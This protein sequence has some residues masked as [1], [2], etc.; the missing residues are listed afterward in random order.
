MEQETLLNKAIENYNVA[1]MIRNQMDGDEA[2]LNYIGY[3]LQQSVEL[4]I[5]YQLDTQGVEYPKTHDIDQLIFI[6]KRN[7]AQLIMTD[8]IEDHSEMF[9]QWESKT[10]YVL[11]YRLEEKKVDSAIHA[12][13]QY[14][15]KI[16]NRE[17]E[18][19]EHERSENHHRSHDLDWDER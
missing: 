12:V 2:F 1:I 3:H 10:R 13:S 7:N 18:L 8:Y 6:A 9:S 16:L 5:K 19:S 4:C 17:I 11:N 15:D 14:L